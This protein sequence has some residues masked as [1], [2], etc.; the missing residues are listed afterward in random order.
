MITLNALQAAYRG[1]RII[2]AHDKAHFPND[3]VTLADGGE[4]RLDTNI[5]MTFLKEEI[6]GEY[7]NMM[8]MN[9]IGELP[10][11]KDP[12]IR[13][14]V[15]ANARTDEKSRMDGFYTVIEGEKS[16]TYTFLAGG[17]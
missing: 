16:V 7:F 5:H 13:T 14:I 12:A 6:A 4:I 10:L 2:H 17:K 9:K 15:L 1:K 3:I 8:I 11:F